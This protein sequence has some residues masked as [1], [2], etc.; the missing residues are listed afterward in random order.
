MLNYCTVLGAE[1]NTLGPHSYLLTTPFRLWLEYANVNND[2][3]THLLAFISPSGS[4]FLSSVY[5]TLRTGEKSLEFCPEIYSALDF[6]WRT[7]P[8]SVDVSPMPASLWVSEHLRFLLQGRLHC[9][10]SLHRLA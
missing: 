3:I 4:I 10:A 5:S 6:G 7:S 8:S 9:W 2:G 1:L